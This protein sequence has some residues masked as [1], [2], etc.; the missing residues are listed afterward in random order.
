MNASPAPTTV[1]SPFATGRWRTLDIVVVAVVAGV[2]VGVDG[3][4][5]GL[6]AADGPS[7]RRWAFWL[8]AALASLALWMGLTA[9][10]MNGG[11]PVGIAIAA[12]LSY[13]LGCAAGCFFLIAVSLRFAAKHLRILGSLAPN[14]YSLYLLHYV[15]VVWLQFALLGTPL[16]AVVK[17]AIVFSGTLV[18][19]W[20]AMIAVQRVPFGARLIGSARRAV[21]GVAP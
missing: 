18:F 19:S 14:A 10:T 11:A 20:I 4:D 12:D 3:I 15:F 21:A 13:V 7:A 16:Y 9:L 2:G 1:G 17:A 6:V 5:R 8:A